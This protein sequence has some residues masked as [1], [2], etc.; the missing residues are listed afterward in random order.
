MKFS[1]L[2]FAG[3]LALIANAFWRMECRARSGLA[4]IDPLISPGEV[5]QHLHSIH[6]GGG[7][8]DNATYDDLM[9]SD[10]TSCAVTEDKSAY[11]H[12][13]LFF[14]DTTTGKYEI[15]QQSGGMLAYYLLFPNTAG[16]K[17]TA[18][19]KGFRM[20]AGD[21]LRRNY[22]SALGNVTQPDP[23]KSDWAKLGQTSQPDLQQRAIGFNCL[24]YA[25]APEGSLYRHYLPDKSYLDANCA[26]GVRFEMMFPSCWNGK[27]T[28]SADHRSHVA[29][30]DLVMTGN[31]PSTHPTRLISLFYEIIWNTAAFKG[32]TGR[33]VISNGDVQ[34]FGYHADFMTGWDV[35]FLQ[36]A[37]DTCTNASGKIQDCSLFTI[38]DDAKA[39]QCQIKVPDAMAHENVTGPGLTALPGDVQI[40]V[41]PQPATEKNPTATSV[42]SLPASYAPGATPSGDQYLPGQVFKQSSEGTSTTSSPAAAAQTPSPDSGNDGAAAVKAEAEA[43]PTTTPVPTTTTPPPQPT[44]TSPPPA[45]TTT[46]T[47]E[48][49]NDGVR[50]EYITIGNLVEKIIWV[51][52][53]KY[54]TQYVDETDVVTVNPLARRQLRHL[55]K[56]AHV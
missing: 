27:D 37:A 25:K 28:D 7:F 47:R 53:I 3:N 15:V 45:P 18:F 13:S 22:S 11:W 55:H 24:N 30:P 14:E 20:I 17:V 32:R 29:Y 8:N 46:L 4:R 19:P 49:S 56:H 44:I 5:A 40:Q 23:Q 42:S 51:E 38:Q 21:S 54:V 33:F 6:G 10:C 16:G 39:A 12:P 48:E 50:T 34:G 43:A 52:D 26:D 31:C 41:G 1:T 9:A 36:K 2:I 35:D